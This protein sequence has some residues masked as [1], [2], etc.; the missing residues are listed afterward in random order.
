VI[1]DLGPSDITRDLSD[2][3]RDEMA[4]LHTRFCRGIGDPKRLLIVAALATGEKTV[5]QLA[6][7]IGA[8]HSN[9]SQ[10]LS[11]MRDLG[12]VRAQRIDNNVYY[13]LS[14]PRLADVVELLRAIQADL[15]QQRS[16][17]IRSP[18]LTSARRIAGVA[19]TGEQ[20]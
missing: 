17:A 15:H 9:I 7:Q 14:D 1:A 8:A 2:S 11:L 19:K 4:E 10:H 18:G 12:L 20:P 16:T 13:R 6:Q 5:G 3:L